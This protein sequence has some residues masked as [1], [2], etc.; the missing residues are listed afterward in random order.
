MNGKHYGKTQDGRDV[1]QFE[2]QNRNGV[3]IK[4]ISYG[5][6]ITNILLPSASGH[7]D[8]VL[9]FDDLAG[10]EAD[11]SS[12]GAFIGRYANRIKGAAFTH[13]GREYKLLKNDGDNYLHGI[14]K[15]HVF[16]AE[17][18]SENQVVFKTLSAAGEEGFPGELKITV[19]Y[20]LDDENR[21]TMEYSAQTDAET[22]INLTNHTYFDLSLGNDETIENHLLR[23]ESNRF[24][25]LDEN[26]LPTGKI[27]ETAG[28]PFDFTHQKTVGRDIASNDVNLKIGRG[29][30]HCFLLEPGA[31]GELILAAE[32]C[33]PGG[34][35]SMRI[36]T[37]QPA[38][39][40]YTGNFLDGAL[41][42]KGRVFTFRSAFCLET[43]HYP[44][45]PHHPEFPST[46]LRPGEDFHE[47]T[48]LQFGF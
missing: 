17:S 38:I 20:A 13:A 36:F 9:G 37:T 35:R 45:T 33:A 41:E 15:K 23:I 44:D 18:V 10:Y 34:E 7:A 30:D 48:V 28:T 16:S 39:Q 8:I 4:C 29:Y 40:F 31:P 24:L 47:T 6:C 1:D 12:Q 11:I 22:H 5:C 27:I 43:Q 3:I 2:L 21:F 19:T 14:L 32:A 25:Q 26:L 46:L 42:G